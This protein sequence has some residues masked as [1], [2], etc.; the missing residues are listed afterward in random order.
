M[1]YQGNSLSAQLLTDGIVEF[2]FDAQGSVNKFDQ[3][4]FGEFK[5][6]IQAIRYCEQ[7]KGVMVTSTKSTF[8]V[9]ADITEFLE[10]FKLEEQDLIPWVKGA[11]DVFDAFEELHHVLLV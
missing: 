3:A 5:A 11:S 8:L 6:V 2:T 1:I 4:T 7:A 10:I 9:G